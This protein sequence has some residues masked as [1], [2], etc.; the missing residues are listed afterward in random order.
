MPC[1][2][3]WKK[4]PEALAGRMGWECGAAALPGRLRREAPMSVRSN[5]T[6]VPK[7]VRAVCMD[8]IPAFCSSSSQ[9]PPP[10]SPRE[11]L[12]LLDCALNP[13]KSTQCKPSSRR[14]IVDTHDLQSHR[15]CWLL[16]NNKL[17][18]WFLLLHNNS[19][20]SVESQKYPIIVLVLPLLLVPR[21]WV[22]VCKDHIEQ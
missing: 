7:W 15:C 13:L 3:T 9:L 4:G 11:E 19:R 17:L 16:D 6:K 1:I 22:S 12:L 20:V 10:A 21:S 5:N 18:V 14:R 8:A 2:N